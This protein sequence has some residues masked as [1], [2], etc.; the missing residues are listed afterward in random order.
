M[1][2][3]NLQTRITAADVASNLADLYGLS[4]GGKPNGRYRVSPKLMRRL[5][6]R[7]RLTE[8][9]IGQLEDEL[10]ELGFSLVDLEL[11][12]AV[13]SVQ[14]FASYRR[15]GEVQVAGLSGAAPSP[16]NMNNRLV[17]DI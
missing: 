17:D 16:D 4:F 14:T 9:F 15:L 6:G 3:N 11:F 12:Y 10:F 2:G 5:S 1:A 13:V 8:A 7:R